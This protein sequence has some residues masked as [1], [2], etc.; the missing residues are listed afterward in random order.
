M[1]AFY[2]TTLIVAAEN[3]SCVEV[4][5][6][7]CRRENSILKNLVDPNKTLGDVERAEQLKELD[8][9]ALSYDGLMK[10]TQL[11]SIYNTVR[12]IRLA[13]WGP[14]RAHVNEDKGGFFFLRSNTKNCEEVCPT[15][16]TETDHYRGSVNFNGHPDW[17]C[18]CYIDFM[19]FAD[20]PKRQ[21]YI[22][23]VIGT[24]TID[25]NEKCDDPRFV[26]NGYDF[27]AEPGFDAKRHVLTSGA[28]SMAGCNL[29]CRLMPNCAMWYW[30]K[31]GRTD[32][33]CYSIHDED[34]NKI[35]NWAPNLGGDGAL[36][37]K[38]TDRTTSS[39]G[40]LF[41]MPC[42]PETH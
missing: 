15:Y 19:Q 16:S 37:Y 4:T 39:L 28:E 18:V 35:T 23:T 36:R 3:Y 8:L 11:T 9:N 30:I 41:G 17:G 29:K 40:S 38:E 5:K 14:D 33:G 1:L 13:A 34:L 21:D 20:Y 42:K 10:A 7:R 32:A 25:P 12:K 6:C 31:D 27:S 24:Y 2:F 26:R 22:D